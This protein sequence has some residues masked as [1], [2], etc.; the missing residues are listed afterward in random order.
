MPANGVPSEVVEWFDNE[1]IA[2][3]RVIFFPRTSLSDYLKLHA[4]VD[5]CLDTFPYT[6]GTTTLHALWMGVP[7]LTIAGDTYP[8]RQSSAILHSV[9]IESMC[10]ARSVPELV[11][12]ARVW[13]TQPQTLNKVRRELQ[14][15][16]FSQD[17]MAEPAA[18]VQST[19][20]AM[21]QMWIR[22]CMGKKPKSFQ[23][24]YED[25]GLTCPESILNR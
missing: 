16:Y 4:Q 5:L 19:I 21:R 14:S 7:T 23:V 25:I 2:S 15:V 13:A 3:E 9:G 22:W 11:D 10:V 20:L 18:V 6:G 12:L 8:G 1:G 24:K 17:Q